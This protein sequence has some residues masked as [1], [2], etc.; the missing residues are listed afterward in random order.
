ME[1]LCFSCS[2]VIVYVVD[3]RGLKAY[4]KP[5][6]EE[7]CRLRKMVTG[8]LLVPSTYR[9]AKDLYNHVALKRVPS[10]ARG[11]A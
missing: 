3:T 9:Q 5:A 7:K 6:C 11:Y 4:A 8:I 2:S 1:T 10:L